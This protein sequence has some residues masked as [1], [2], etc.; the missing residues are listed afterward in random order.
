MKQQPE[1]QEAQAKLEWLEP[2]FELLNDPEGGGGT[3][4][5]SFLSGPS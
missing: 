5:E 2:T 3:S 4:S 1:N